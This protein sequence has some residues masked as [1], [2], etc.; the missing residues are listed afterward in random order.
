MDETSLGQLVALYGACRT[1]RWY[2][3][4]HYVRNNKS[5]KGT[6]VAASA[7]YTKRRAVKRNFLYMHLASHHASAV[8]TLKVVEE[9]LIVRQ[10]VAVA[11]H[12][13]RFR[14]SRPRC[15]GWIPISFEYLI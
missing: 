8:L 2:K 10:H 12:K 14:F 15:T 1:V 9:I 6:A 11:R 4:A 5:I 7:L 13:G 3:L